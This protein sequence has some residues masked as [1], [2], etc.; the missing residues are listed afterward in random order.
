MLDALSGPIYHRLLVPYDD[1]PLSD[2]F[3][4][5]VVEHVFGGLERSTAG[6]GRDQPARR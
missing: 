1:A 2:A 6:G 3:V 5:R 4:D